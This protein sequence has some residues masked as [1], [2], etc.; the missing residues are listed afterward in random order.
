MMSNKST[1][2]SGTNLGTKLL[3]SV[4]EMK[5]GKAVRSTIITTNEAAE[6]RLKAGSP[7]AMPAQAPGC[8]R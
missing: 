7:Q 3:K 8:D 4:K 1:L 6:A 2:V 5:A